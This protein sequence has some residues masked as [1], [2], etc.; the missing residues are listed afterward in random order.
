[1]WHPNA[2]RCLEDILVR[3]FMGER[4]EVG[5]RGAVRWYGMAD[6][7]LTAVGWMKLKVAS[8]GEL[9]SDLVW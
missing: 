1:M 8:G 2:S 5:G 4:G 6:R 3:M 7:V 9:P